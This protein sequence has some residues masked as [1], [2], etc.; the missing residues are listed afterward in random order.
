MVTGTLGGAQ[1]TLARELGLPPL[2]PA[3][4]LYHLL[5]DHGRPASADRRQARTRYELR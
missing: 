1:A 3:R 2:V 4:R 5:V